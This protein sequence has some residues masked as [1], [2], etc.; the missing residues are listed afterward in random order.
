M[1][2]V[3][4][5]GSTFKLL[6]KVAH[7]FRDFHFFVWLA[8]KRSQECCLVCSPFASTTFRSRSWLFKSS[9]SEF[10]SDSVISSCI[11]CGGL[12]DW[13]VTTGSTRPCRTR[14][15]ISASYDGCEH[16]GQEIASSRMPAKDKVRSRRWRKR[17]AATSRKVIL[18]YRGS[19]IRAKR[20]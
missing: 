16:A 5:R 11:I 6:A 8:E 1:M 7:R 4:R 2:L 17:T 20:L 10:S 12:F 19:S 13:E 15:F 14:I 3:L 9:T 18:P